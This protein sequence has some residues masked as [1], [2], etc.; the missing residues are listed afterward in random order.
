MQVA[1]ALWSS[2]VRLLDDAPIRAPSGDRLRFR[3]Q[4]QMIARSL[5]PESAGPIVVHVDGDWGRGKT[6]FC[7]LLETELLD[8]RTPGAGRVKTRWYIASAAGGRPEAELMYAVVSAVLDGDPEETQRIIAKWGPSDADETQVL[9]RRT[10]LFEWIEHEL[11]WH[12]ASRLD[13]LSTVGQQRKEEPFDIPLPDE[14][15]LSIPVAERSTQKAVV[16]VDDLDR[17]TPERVTEVLVAVRQYVQCRGLCFV[18]AADHSVIKAAFAETRSATAP[19]EAIQ[20]FIALEKYIR[21]TVRLP[22]IAGLSPSEREEALKKIQSDVTTGVSESI[23]ASDRAELA[24]GLGVLLGRRCGRSLTLRRLK[25]IL[26]E[27]AGSLSSAAD[28]IELLDDSSEIGWSRRRKTLWETLDSNSTPIQLNFSS[29]PPGRAEGFPGYFLGR[30]IVEPA[31]YLWP[32][33]YDA[34]SKSEDG[35][36]GLFDHCLWPTVYRE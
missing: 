23:L 17:C 24:D 13:D 21:H 25:R 15:V 29:T 33:L 26:N 4:V 9:V 34:H 5:R 14:S 22:R 32:A 30:A 19:T 11:G 31:R 27:L 8:Q 1:R 18:V 36:K 6:S 2:N 7:Q 16:F 10:Q 28:A 3:P 35:G 20:A 12:Q